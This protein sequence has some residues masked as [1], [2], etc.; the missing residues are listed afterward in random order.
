[1]VSPPSGP[2]GENNVRPTAHR[3][4][5]SHGFWK[6]T[7]SVKLFWFSSRFDC[8]DLRIF[9]FLP[10][11]HFLSLKVAGACQSYFREKEAVRLLVIKLNYKYHNHYSNVQLSYHLNKISPVG[12]ISHMTHIFFRAHSSVTQELLD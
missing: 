10:A 12:C 8:V 4:D 3:K 7:E 6:E 1:M 5:M 9:F 11:T 2:D